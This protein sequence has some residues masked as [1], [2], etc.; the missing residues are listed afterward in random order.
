MSQPGWQ[1][2]FNDASN[3]LD[4]FRTGGGNN[5]GDYSNPAFDRMLE[6]RA[7]RSRHRQP[8]QE[9]GGG[10]SASS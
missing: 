5:W 9:I 10:G 7:E 2:D 4:L 1:A 3:F 6:C 8:R